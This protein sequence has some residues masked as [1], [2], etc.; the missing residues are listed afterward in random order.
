MR[1]KPRLRKYYEEVV[2][3]ELSE[4]YGNPMAVPKLEKIVINCGLGGDARD[5]KH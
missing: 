1:E 2:I 3:K 5:R 4:K